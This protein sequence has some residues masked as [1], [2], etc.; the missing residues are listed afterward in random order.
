FSR[1]L[2]L[3]TGH[4]LPREIVESLEQKDGAGPFS[5]ED[6]SP[7]TRVPFVKLP[8]GIFRLAPTLLN[9]DG[10][11]ED[12]CRLVKLKPA[13][14]PYAKMNYLMQEAGLTARQIEIACLIR[15]GLDNQEIAEHLFISLHTTKNH[16]KNLFQKLGIHSRTKLI[17]LLNE[18]PLREPGD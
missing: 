13:I 18:E 15:D 6:W 12:R 5:L 16:I 9:P 7:R 10:E 8:N 14:E 2:P 3:D 4:R 17:A 11:P 1:I